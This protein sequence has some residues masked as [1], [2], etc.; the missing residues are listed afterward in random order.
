MTRTTILICVTGVL[1]GLSGVRLAQAQNGACCN[2]SGFCTIDTAANCAATNG[3]YQ[4]DGTTCGAGT[5]VGGCAFTDTLTGDPGCVTASVA[6][7]NNQVG[8]F[9]G[10][11]STCADLPPVFI[12]P[13]GG[14][15]NMSGASLFADFFEF[16]AATNDFIN[17]DNDFSPGSPICPQPL[18]FAGFFD[19]ECAGFFGVDQLAPTWTCGPWNGHWLLQY[20]AVGSGTGLAEFVDYQLLGQLPNTIPTERGLINRARWSVSGALVDVGLTCAASCFPAVGT[21]DMNCDAAFDSRDI[22]AFLDAVINQQFCAASPPQGDFNSDFVV[23]INDTAGFVDCLLQGGCHESNTQTGTPVCP[24]SIDIA[25]MDVPTKWFTRV[26]TNTAAAAWNVHPTS[27]GY[28]LNPN[29]SN[30]SQSNLLKSLDRGSMGLNVNTDPPIT[31]PPDANTVYDT[32]VVAAAITL[33]SNRGTGLRDTTYTDLQYLYVTGR[34]PSGENLVAATRDSGSGT[35]N[36]GMNTLGVDP[37]WAVG[38]NV[39]N[40]TFDKARHNVGRFNN[41][42]PTQPTHAGG[43]TF[44]ETAVQNWRLAVGY[45][46][47]FG[48]TRAAA[49]ALGGKYEILNVAKNVA[50]GTVFVRPSVQAVVINNDVNTGWQIGALETFA[51]RG[52]PQSGVNGN[53]N[54]PMTNLAARD[55]LRNLTSSIASF[56]SAGPSNVNFNMPA[57]VLTQTFVLVAAVDRV[58]DSTNPA[59]SVPNPNFNQFVQD[60]VLATQITVVPPFGSVNA[61]TGGFVPK[62]NALTD[63]S[64]YSDGSTNGDYRDFG[65]LFA[66]N[67][68]QQ[69]FPRMRIQGDFN[70]DGARNLN[71]AALLM[72][73][74]QDPALFEQN[75]SNGLVGDGLGTTFDYIVPEILGDFNGD[76]DFNTEDVRYWADGLALDIVTGHLNRKAGFTAVDTEWQALTGGLYF[77]DAAAVGT[78]V[79]LANPNATYKAGDARADVAGNAAPTTPTRGFAPTGADNVIDA[80]D[81][82]Y[83]KANFFGAGVGTWGAVTVNGAVVQNA[84]LTDHAARDL[85]CDTNGDLVVDIGDVTEIVVNILQTQIGDVDLNGVVN[86]ADIAVIQANAGSTGGWA[87][88]DVNCD[89]VVNLLDETAARANCTECP[90]TCP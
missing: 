14:Q 84:F 72:V 29:A 32:S 71:D 6:I 89:G 24:T 61:G 13:N 1:C 85:S 55:F 68:S 2:T 80:T 56:V 16:A 10:F 78:P 7:C 79:T 4:G 50:G 39:G 44:M 66:I 30:T 51:T 74:I 70:A 59:N 42:Q 48:P 54:P 65:G 19:T 25:T 41:T 38:D 77:A 40:K 43:S 62:R 46:G 52:D 37:S 11:G 8:L 86:C 67:S 75:D 53:A 82:D 87:M 64:T 27:P 15:I 18:P 63:G 26:G 69:V 73:A 36:G 49:D 47:L 20:R 76:G 31:A 57:E 28:G 33:L 81:I 21:S 9:Q 34:M 60:S 12:Y 90:V 22:Q 35:R 45:T 83:V 23:D 17:V 58:P 88:G 3:F 5:C